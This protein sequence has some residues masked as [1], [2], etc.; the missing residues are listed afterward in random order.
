MQVKTRL[1]KKIAWKSEE[2]NFEFTSIGTPQKN[3]VI[4]QGFSALYSWVSTITLYMGI[5]EYLKTGICKKC[6]ATANKFENIMVNLHEE[7]CAYEKFYCKIPD[8]AKHLKTL[9]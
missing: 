5:H 6:T 8:Y 4:E 9:V 1:L 2:I 7:K 3:G